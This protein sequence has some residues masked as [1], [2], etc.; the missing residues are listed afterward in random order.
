MFGK[1]NYSGFLGKGFGEKLLGAGKGLARVLDEPLVQAGI[2]AIS[3]EVGV[4]L[5]V[6]KRSGL[7]EKLKH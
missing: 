2:T 6:A 7:L 4:A 1:N 3:P 5:G